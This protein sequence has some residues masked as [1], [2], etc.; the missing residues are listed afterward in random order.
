M[1]ANGSLRRVTS[2]MLKPII[3]IAILQDNLAIHHT[4]C[5]NRAEG[6]TGSKANVDLASIRHFSPRII[7][8]WLHKLVDNWLEQLLA[9][10]PANSPTKVFLN[11]FFWGS[12]SLF[13]PVS[14][15]LSTPVERIAPLQN[16][17]VRTV[18]QDA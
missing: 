2:G 10:V 3:A 15:T 9:I 13:L 8:G 6:V 17:L 12:Q 7:K 18:K 11:P 16:K 4:Q 14:N 5:S 1:Y